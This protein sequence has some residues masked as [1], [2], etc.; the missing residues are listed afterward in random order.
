MEKIT[1]Q[2]RSRKKAMWLLEL[3]RS[4]DFIESIETEQNG[5]QVGE[6]SVS[7]SEGDEQFFNMAGLWAGRDISLDSIRRR[8][9]PRQKPDPL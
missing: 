3:L 5:G 9:W 2:L 1:V 4:F 8:A 6:Q 7:V